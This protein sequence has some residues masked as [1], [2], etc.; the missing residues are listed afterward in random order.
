MRRV[1]FLALT[2]FVSSLIA[3][4]PA[5]GNGSGVGDGGG[6]EGGGSGGV[7]LGGS[8][9]TAAAGQ[10]GMIIQG[11][12]AGGGGTGNVCQELTVETKPVTPTVLILVDN[13]SS[14]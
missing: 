4:S 9:G 8:A 14:M 12:A 5:P 10:G 7:P 6:D 2:V 13:S 1:D 3:C 11:G